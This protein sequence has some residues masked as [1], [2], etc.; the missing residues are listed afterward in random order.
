MIKYIIG[1]VGL[2]ATQFAF[3]QGLDSKKLDKFLDALE[4][5]DRFMGSVSISKSGK[6]IYSKSVGYAALDEEKKANKKTI[7]RIGSISKMFTSVMIFQLIEE[8]KLGEHTKL[9]KFYPDLPNADKITIG[10]LLNHHSGLHNFT[11]D[12]SYMEWMTEGKTKEE[13]LLMFQ[14]NGADFEAGE[15]ASYSNTGYVV[16]GY[17]IEKLTKMSYA[18][19]LKKRITDKIGLKNTYYGGKI[20]VEKE[21]ALSYQW[22]GGKWIAAT[23]TDMGIP[24]GAGAVVS[25]PEDLNSFINALF[26]HKLIKKK[27]LDLMVSIEDGFGFGVFQFPFKQKRSLGHNGGIDG[28]TSMVAH[29]ANEDIAIAVVSNGTNYAFNNVLIGLLS[30]TF[31]DD[32]EIPSFKTY[33][34]KEED[35]KRFEGVYASPQLPIKLT[36]TKEGMILKGQGTGQAAFPL[37]AVDKLLFKFEQAGVVIEFEAVEKGAYQAFLLKQGGGEYKFTREKE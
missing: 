13:M 4:Q 29:F 30:I 20:D 32:Y 21:E 18:E 34:H 17:I 27:T 14:F 12:A 9:S 28:F 25:T 33:K 37:E 11:D 15:K 3:G 36:I 1:L 19:A 24:G 10:N 16:L 7:Y 6:K 8:G 35:L 5:N 31:G 2:F 26:S 23:E 22:D